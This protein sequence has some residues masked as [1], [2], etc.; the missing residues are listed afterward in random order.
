MKLL[1]E[2][3]D[4]TSKISGNSITLKL[5]TSTRLSIQ[6]IIK[7]IENYPKLE[8]QDIYKFVLQGSCGWTHLLSNRKQENVVQHL[9]EELNLASKP[10]PN[11]RLFD[12]LNNETALCRI[13]LRAW[14]NDNLGKL[15]E[16]WGLMVKAEK[17]TPKSTKIFR[18]NWKELVD[19]S[20]N[21]YIVTSVREEYMV[22]QWMKVVLKLTENIEKSSE[23]PLIHHSETYRIN[24]KP[25]YRLVNENDLLDFIEK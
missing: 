12:S 6:P 9:N 13:N 23:M 20:E 4:L 14:K 22:L 21:G 10:H 5:D 19:L 3:K 1:T 8:W 7:H 2:F 24:Y 25:S 17:S 18:E 15:H 16:L 11:E